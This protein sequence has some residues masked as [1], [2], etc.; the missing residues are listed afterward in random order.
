MQSN[1]E[2]AQRL[3]ELIAE[4]SRLNEDNAVLRALG[5]VNNEN[6]ALRA[7]YGELIEKLQARG[8]F[9]VTGA[10]V[11][12]LEIPRDLLLPWQSPF[13]PQQVVSLGTQRTC[14]GFQVA[15]AAVDNSE[16]PNNLLLCLWQSPFAPYLAAT[17][18]TE[19]ALGGF[20]VAGGPSTS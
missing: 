17:Q 12:I 2:S 14:G 7:L 5:K 10:A 15:G 16:F 13:T 20:Q 9:Q 18:E 8:G 19:Q 3:E 6:A 4:D 11:D 1:R